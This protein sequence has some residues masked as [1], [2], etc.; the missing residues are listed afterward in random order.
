MHPPE[1]LNNMRKAAE[2]IC[3]DVLDAAFENSPNPNRKPAAAFSGLDDMINRMRKEGLI[4]SSIEN[5]LGSLKSFGNFASH[6]QEEDPQNTSVEMAES[7]LLHLRT[8]VEWYEIQ[9]LHIE[10]K[11]K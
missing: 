7:T 1:A 2:A 9:N 10:Q 5:C 3:K 6:D 4:P 11:N 8:L